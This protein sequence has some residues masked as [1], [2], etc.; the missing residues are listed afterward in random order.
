MFDRNLHK[1]F[2]FAGTSED[3]RGDSSI[4]VIGD[5]ISCTLGYSVA[6]YFTLSGFPKIPLVIY[7]LTEFILSQ[8]IRDNLM[9]IVV[10][11]FYPIDWIREWQAENIPLTIPK[12][13]DDEPEV[14]EEGY[15]RTK[16]TEPLKSYKY[17]EKGE[18]SSKETKKN[19]IRQ[20]GIFRYIYNNFTS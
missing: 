8:T 1:K 10:Q 3:Y 19:E 16:Y 2:S 12:D 17:K 18:E 15:W 5:L 13:A 6:K 4:N 14:N 7:F 20:I 11:L 9:L